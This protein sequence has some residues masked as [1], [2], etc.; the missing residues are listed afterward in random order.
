MAG[1]PAGW[2]GTGE[3]LV[4]V[5]WRPR[6]RLPLPS[7]LR[8]LPGAQLVVAARYATSPVGP[9]L[10]LAVAQPAR[11][12]TRP[13]MCVT[14][15]ACGSAAAS[16]AGRDGWGFPKEQADLRWSEEGSEMTLRWEDR[17]IMVHG[18]TKAR[19]LSAVLPYS[20]L[21]CRTDGP[22]WVTGR[23]RGW[24][25]LARVELIVPAD[26]QLS[27]LVGS[28]RGAFFGN[29]AVKMGAARRL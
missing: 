17:G 23:L 8:H 20:S 14:T 15:I 16:A 9:Y 21:Q 25:R 6:G 27:F 1:G 3:C 11:H 10:E 24:A 7:G 2:T 22:V 4:C 12:G 28:H 13:G 5:V 19:S 29:A 18:V 26:D